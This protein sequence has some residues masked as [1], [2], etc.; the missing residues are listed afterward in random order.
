MHDNEPNR[1]SRRSKRLVAA[2]GLLLASGIAGG[3]L[4]RQAQLRQQTV[5]S[6]RWPCRWAGQLQKGRGAQ[7]IPPSLCA[8]E[9]RR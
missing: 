6:R 7:P 8:P 3:H 5:R 2:V 1:A 4:P 9:R